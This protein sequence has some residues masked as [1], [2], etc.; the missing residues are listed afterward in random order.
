MAG[1]DPGSHLTV[2]QILSFHDP[3]TSYLI[4]HL[5]PLNETCHKR[6]N[7]HVRKPTVIS[8]YTVYV[9]YLVVALIWRFGESRLYHRI[10]CTP[11]RL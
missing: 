8:L 6:V 3:Q 9:V 4:H 1:R 11:F 7:V 2:V 10:N 5:L